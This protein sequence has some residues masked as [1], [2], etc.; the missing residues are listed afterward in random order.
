MS[1]EYTA[2]RRRIQGEQGNVEQF[3]SKQTDK[4]RSISFG[5]VSA[6]EDA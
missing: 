5:D 6:A 2:D 3:S 4:T 1:A